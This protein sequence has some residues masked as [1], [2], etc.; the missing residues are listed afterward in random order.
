MENAFTKKCLDNG[1][2]SMI[3][4]AEVWVRTVAAGFQ[5]SDAPV[6]DSKLPARL[7]DTF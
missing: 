6:D 2:F 7:L 4:D 5:E 3:E 1:G